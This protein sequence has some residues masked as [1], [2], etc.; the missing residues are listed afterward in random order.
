MNP[1][2]LHNARIYESDSSG[3]A[4]FLATNQSVQLALKSWLETLTPA[5]PIR[6]LELGSGPRADRWQIIA[7][8]PKTRDYQVTLSD[9]SHNALPKNLDKLDQCILRAVK[10]DLLTDPFPM[11]TFDVILATYVFDSI[12]FPEDMYINRFHF[13]GGLI[14]K[15]R[16]AFT[17]CLSPQGV[18]ISIDRT[19]TKFVPE[20]ETSGPAHF[21]TENYEIAQSDL[22]KYGFRVQLISLNTFL[23]TAGKSLPLDL[24]D[25]SVLIVQKN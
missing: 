15:V 13:P 24:S 8:E 25:H 6:L 1:H 10:L 14:A 18:F 21:K 16:Q 2:N 12:W 20:Y 9:F 22:Q 19:S 3:V 17:S 7:K 11:R 23:Q 4:D 5:N